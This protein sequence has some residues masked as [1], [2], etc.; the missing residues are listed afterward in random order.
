MR[1]YLKNVWRK[2]TCRRSE[3]EVRPEQD[4][5]I[6]NIARD[7]TEVT[8]GKDDDNIQPIRSLPG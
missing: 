7:R 1:R 6:S 3:Q 4:M 5:T 2:M 8:E